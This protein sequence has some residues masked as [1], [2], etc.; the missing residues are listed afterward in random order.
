MCSQR[1]PRIDREFAD[2]IGGNLGIVKIAEANFPPGDFYACLELS[3]GFAPG[4]AAAILAGSAA[5]VANVFALDDYAQVSL[6][7]VESVVL[8]VINDQAITR[9][10]HEAV[11]KHAIS[12]AI[13]VDVMSLGAGV[14]VGIPASRA[15]EDFR[16]VRR[17]DLRS[18]QL[19][20]ENELDYGEKV[21]KFVGLTCKFHPVTYL[22]TVELLLSAKRPILKVND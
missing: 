4:N 20:G 2:L 15:G 22:V 12:A 7:I 17:V 8:D 10:S 1:H 13:V 19:I 3:A 16:E 18:N 5:C 9:V 14:P 6:A 21:E 11:E